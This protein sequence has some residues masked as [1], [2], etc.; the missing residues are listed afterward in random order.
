MK[1]EKARLEGVRREASGIKLLIYQVVKRDVIASLVPCSL[2]LEKINLIMPKAITA[3]ERAQKTVEKLHKK[4]N[5]LGDQVFLAE[6]I[7]PTLNKEILP[8]LQENQQAPVPGQNGTHGQELDA[9]TQCM[10]TS[11]VPWFKLQ[12]PLKGR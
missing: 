11:P 2:T 3:I 5:K 1:K 7:F 4:V 12:T 10:A 8:Q 9:D 6:D